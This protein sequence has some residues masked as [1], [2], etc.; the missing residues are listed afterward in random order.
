M[1]LNKAV[2]KKLIV[3]TLQE[4]EPEKYD[5]DAFQP[6][7]DEPRGASKEDF[8]PEPKDLGHSEDDIAGY[9]R[10]VGDELRQR[11]DAYD[12]MP[13]TK[14]PVRSEENLRVALAEMDRVQD[15]LEEI[16]KVLQDLEKRSLR[17]FN[18]TDRD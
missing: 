12:K 15:E 7:S 3:E 2:L 18:D 4:A 16:K 17:S 6:Y 14:I 1:K 9:F 5:P 8:G 10:Q 11:I 13:K